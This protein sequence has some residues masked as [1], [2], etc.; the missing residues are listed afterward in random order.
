[1]IYGVAGSGKTVIIRSRA[2]VLSEDPERLT[3]LLCFNR[4]LAAWFKKQLG[5]HSNLKVA[6]FGTWARSQGAPTNE[7]AEHFGSGLLELLQYGRAVPN[8]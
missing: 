8:Q 5:H 2:K 3:L 6:T 7:N 4:S 1:M